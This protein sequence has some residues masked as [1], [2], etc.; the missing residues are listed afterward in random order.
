MD[1][2]LKVAGGERADVRSNP[3]VN[4]KVLEDKN[5]REAVEDVF[6]GICKEAVDPFFLLDLGNVVASYKTWE[7]HLGGIRPYYAVKANNDLP[8][9]KILAS[10]GCGFEC[11]SKGEIEAVLSLGVPPSDISYSNTVKDPEHIRY[12]VSENVHLTVVDNEYELKKIHHL[13]KDAIFLL[14]VD[15]YNPASPVQMGQKFGVTAK[16]ACVLV[17][18]AHD[19][20]IS[21]SGVCFHIGQCGHGAVYKKAVETSR[22]IFDY[23]QHTH[24]MQMTIL[25]MGGGFPGEEK[26]ADDF[27][28][29]ATVI[30]KSISD[31]FGDVI[32]LQVIAEPG[33]YF[34]TPT[35]TTFAKVISK[36]LIHNDGEKLFWYYLNDGIFGSYL[37][38]SQFL[39][40]RLN[41]SPLRLTNSKKHEKA[42]NEDNLRVYKSAIFGH[43]SAPEDVLCT[44]IMLPELDIGDWMYCKEFLLIQRKLC[45]PWSVRLARFH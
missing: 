3:T 9:M 34:A 26:S 22:E 14:R 20:G 16:D 39:G 15:I 28:E 24:G 38:A 33:K 42:S 27:K 21:F 8:M 32:G 6:R 11:A 17:D 19:L 41:F 2:M 12:A 37:A 36:R 4:V 44:D 18:I 13:D 10:L 23:A 43:Y 30:K 29:L 1:H 25:N 5:N 7:H 31:S 35:C 45:V 40:K